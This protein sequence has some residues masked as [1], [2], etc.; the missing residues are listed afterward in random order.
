MANYLQEDKGFSVK[1][2]Q[3]LFQCRMMDIDVKA[4][5]KWK[6][7]DLNCRAC[8]QPNQI[9]NQQHILTCETLLNRNMKLTYLPTYSGL[10]SHDIE[11]QMYTSMIICENLRLSLVPM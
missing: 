6:Y 5:R 8:N 11:D 7:E 10:Y 3:S 1:E 4:N 9:E 2:K